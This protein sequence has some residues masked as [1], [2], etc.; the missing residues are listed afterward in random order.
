MR[1][2]DHRGH[3]RSEG[4]RTSIVRFD[5]YVDDLTMV[6]AAAHEQWRTLPLILLGHSMGGLIAL[7]FAVRANRHRSTR[8]C[9]RRRRH[10]RVTSRG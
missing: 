6:I 3:G 5:D 7:S 9:S 1:A 4:R 10:A 8:W 2:P